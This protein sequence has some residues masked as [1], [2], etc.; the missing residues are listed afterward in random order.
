MVGR[1]GYW[2]LVMSGGGELCWGLTVVG[3]VIGTGGF[4]G[5]CWWWW[6][7]VVMGSV[8]STGLSSLNPSGFLMNTRQRLN[9]LLRVGLESCPC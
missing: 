9:S 8:L 4:G 1:G 3:G 5:C 6:V 7:L 2:W